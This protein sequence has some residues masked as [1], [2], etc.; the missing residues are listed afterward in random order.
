[1]NRNSLIAAPRAWLIVSVATI[2]VAL[3]VIIGIGPTWGIDFTGGSL[4]E[5]EGRPEGVTRARQILEQEFSLPASAQ[6]TQ[7]GS[8]LI[9]TQTIDSPTHESILDRL[10]EEGILEGEER[11]FEAI[12]PTIGRELRRKTAQAVS[13]V[14][15]V[16][17]VYL[18]Y[19]FRQTKGLVSSWK[20]G[21]GAAW[22]LIHD[23]VLITAL[24]V[25]FGK[26]WGASIDTLFVTAQLAILGYSVNDTIVVF[27]R[28]VRERIAAKKEPLL[29]VMNKAV[30]A[31]LGRSINTALTTLLVLLSLVLFGGSTIHWFVVALTAGVITGTYSSIFVAPPMLWYLT[32][33]HGK[34]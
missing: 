12:G 28:L 18:A 11:R 31:T 27:D 4:I 3:A 13:L 32:K 34:S 24:F 8:I 1:M 10:R 19:T 6:A 14:V 17:I 2:V 33:K 5:I 21:V 25:V 23:L 20:F 9:R 30:A 7:D 16:M 22:A 26:I 29:A 15:L